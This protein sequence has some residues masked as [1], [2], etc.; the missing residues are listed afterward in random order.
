MVLPARSSRLMVIGRDHAEL[1]ELDAEDRRDQF[2]SH[3]AARQRPLRRPTQ[4]RW[5]AE[6]AFQIGTH[7]L[8]DV[9]NDQRAGVEAEVDRR[10]AR[11]SFAS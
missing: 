2:A 11:A 9:G 10:R 3:F 8:D 4:A 7:G 6:L 1:K 5:V